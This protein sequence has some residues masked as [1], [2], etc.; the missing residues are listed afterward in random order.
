MTAAW[1][2]L[3]SAAASRAAESSAHS[4]I[5]RV[6]LHTHLDSV[7][8]ADALMQVAAVLEERHQVRLAVVFNL[9]PFQPVGKPQPLTPES[10]AEM[11]KR[12]AGRILS[13]I[14]DYNVPA[15]L[16]YSPGELATWKERGVVGYKIWYPVVIGRDPPA[17]DQFTIHTPDYPG[18]DSPAN[19]PVFAAMERL[20]MVGTGIHIGQALPRRWENP[21]HFWTAIHS[22]LRVMDRHPRLVVVM[23]HMMNLFYSDEQ[24]DFL[25]YVLE[26]Y[27][28]LHVEIGGRFSDFHAMRRDHLRAF[29][30]QY[31]DR[32]LYGTDF[33]PFALR[34]G[35][36]AGA[37]RYVSSFQLLES[38]A[39]VSMA[40]GK[41]PAKPARGLA[42]PTDVLEKIYHLNAA[43]LYPRVKEV[44]EAQGY[45]LD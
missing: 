6:D 1:L 27:P 37:T 12:Y 22:W 32:I 17:P 42:L 9:Q 38:D 28:N 26:T 40:V 45:R 16:R 3:A 8:T 33:A 20:G 34:D 44:L 21:V 7:A 14:G 31:A 35:T 19:A 10:F 13:C 24:L 15:G 41:A 30:I 25:R 43:R 2:I 11:E 29:M 23:A 4:R 36:E 18:I 5:P 39:A